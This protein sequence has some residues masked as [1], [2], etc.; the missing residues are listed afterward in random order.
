[1]NNTDIYNLT[2][3]VPTPVWE[4]FQIRVRDY[5]FLSVGRVIYYLVEAYRKQYEGKKNSA[6]MRKILKHA[7]EDWFILFRYDK[8]SQSTICVHRDWATKIGEIAR[9]S[10]Y[11]DRSRLIAVLIGCFV[12]SSGS[13][14]KKMCQEMDQR[15][16]DISSGVEILSTY[17][18]FYQYAVLGVV[19]KRLN[20]SISGL[21]STLLDVVIRCEDESADLTVSGDIRDLINDVLTIKG[22]TV[23]DFRREKDI[24]VY[25]SEKKRMSVLQLI[26]KYNISTPSEFLRRLVLFF[27]N[28][29]YVL[30]K[31]G[32]QFLI[33]KDEDQEE[34]DTFREYPKRDYARNNLMRI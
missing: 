16:I 5:R 26:K 24:S 1:M 3:F 12:S 6:V 34:D 18:G 2:Y 4:M 19:A 28:A 9:A 11:K 30:L 23:K 31:N 10:G 7:T 25:I 29:Q 20:Q 17:I 14:L 33:N 15:D 32:D 21:L 27:L 8:R 13:L 22:Y